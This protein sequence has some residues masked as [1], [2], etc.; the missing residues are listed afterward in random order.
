MTSNDARSGRPVPPD[1]FT[2]P[3]SP[4]AK[5]TATAPAPSVPAPGMPPAP[6]GSA[7][8]V[9]AP[10]SPASAPSVPAFDPTAFSPPPAS[11]SPE[12]PP[13][14]GSVPPVPVA[15]ARSFEPKDWLVVALAALEAV[16]WVEIFDFDLGFRFGQVMPG[17]GMTVFTFVGFSCLFIALGRRARIDR[18]TVPLLVAT[19]LLALIPAFFGNQ[20]LRVLNS[21]ML[22]VTGTFTAFMVAGLWEGAWARFGAFLAAACHFFTSQFAHLLKPLQALKAACGQDLSSPRSGVVRGVAAGLVLAAVLLVVVVPLLMSADQV[23]DGLVGGWRFDISLTDQIGRVLYGLV[24][25]P[26]LFGLLWGFSRTDARPV[27][28]GALSA[29]CSWGAALVPVAVALVCLDVVY[30]VFCGVQFVYLFGGAQTA[31]MQG[32][33]AEYARSGFF[34]LVAVAALNLAVGLAAARIAGDADSIAVPIEQAPALH[35]V[36]RGVALVRVLN[37]VLLVCT[38]VILA[39]AAWRMGLYIAAYGLSVLRMLTLLGMAFIL[40]CLVACAA[41]TFAAR[42]NF[43]RVFF[44]SGVAL[45]IAFNFLNVD[46]TLANYNVDRYIAGDLEQMDTS[47]LFETSPDALP[48][49]E[50]LLAHARATGDEQIDVHALE[51]S[52]E[53]ERLAIKDCPWQYRSLSYGGVG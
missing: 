3:E 6:A 11:T 34:Q 36:R 27:A 38:A 40:V 24:V 32:G 42:F 48:A 44:V 50:R 31:L 53:S 49:L 28:L 29:D 16:L 33:Y 52:I 10:E 30:L 7:P 17:I 26:V 22:W 1:G 13:A 25:A 8:P 46:S 4:S 39:S 23:F 18:V 2:A 45:W 19:A 21:F 41:R 47:Y 20:D 37:L 14:A 51:W 12:P 9:P 15:P 35:H 5:G 43:F